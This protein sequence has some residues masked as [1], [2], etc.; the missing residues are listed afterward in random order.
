VKVVAQTATGPQVLYESDFE[1]GEESFVFPGGCK[2]GLSIGPCTNGWQHISAADGGSLDHAYYL[3]MRDRSGFD[4]EGKGQNDRAP[5]AFSPGL[6]LTYTDEAHG[7]GNARTADPPA[8]SPLDANPEPGNNL[9][10]LNDAAFTASSS[11]SD[12]GA[13]W[14]DNYLDPNRP[15]QRWRFDFN[16][17]T[18]DVLAMAGDDIG[19]ATLPGN[20]TGDVRFALNGGCGTYDYGHMGQGGGGGGQEP[21]NLPPTAVIQTKPASP[22]AN[23][24]VRFDASGS[25]DDKQVSGELTYRWDFTSD[26]TWDASGDSL[27]YAYSAAG[28]YTATLEAT[29]LEGASGRATVEIRVR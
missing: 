14:V 20:L 3:E 8:Q 21:T 13:G 18:F 24:K 9:P 15:D 25:T 27:R 29:D 23:Q 22:N 6:L 2:D 10:N 28:T 7:Y 5:I 17:L 19:P 26:G 12:S 16:C 1:D 11:F 4:L